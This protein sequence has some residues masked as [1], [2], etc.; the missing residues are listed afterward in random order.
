M[1]TDASG[2]ILG[3]QRHYPF[4]ETRLTTGTIYTDMLFTGQREMRRPDCP[5]G[6]VEGWHLLPGEF[7]KNIHISVCSL[8]SVVN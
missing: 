7:E 2:N 6:R 1:V 5:I 3:E 8:F 4:G